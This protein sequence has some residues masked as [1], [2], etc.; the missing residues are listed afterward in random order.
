[1]GK[2]GPNEEAKCFNPPKLRAMPLSSVKA[3]D[4][5]CAEPTIVEKEFH[6]ILDCTASG[7][8]EVHWLFNNIDLDFSS[9]DSYQ[10]AGN[11]SLVIPKGSPVHGFTCTADYGVIPRRTL[12]QTPTTGHRPQF[13]FKPRDSSYREGTAVKLHCEVIGE[14]RPSITWYHRRQVTFTCKARGV[15]KPE[16]TWF[17]EGSI[18][19]HIKGRFMVSDDGSELTVTKVTRQDDGV[20]SCMAGNSVG[21]MMADA[22]LTVDGDFG[23]TVNFLKFFLICFLNLFFGKS[24][25]VFLANKTFRLL[26]VDAFIDDATLKSISTQARDN[27]NR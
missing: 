5:P 14:P 6:S 9:A 18:I 4:V 25:E 3:A 19:P 23:R 7:G 15:P 13:T 10:V 24:L 27:V 2:S 11:G 8:G 21:A 12:R 16:I 22:K 20:Y 17:Y 26:Q 1:M